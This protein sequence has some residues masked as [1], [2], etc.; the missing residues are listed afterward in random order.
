[1]CIRPLELGADIV[2]H[3]ATKYLA[4]HNDTLAGVLVA[5]AP[6]VA[7]ELNFIRTM[8]GG[9]LAPFDCW[10]TLRGIKTLGVRM[11]RSQEN[12]LKLAMWLAEHPAVRCVYY[13]GL[14]EHAT[15]EIF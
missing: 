11:E 13:P 4:G 12:A 7:D 10:L 1:W 9:V 8:T 2:V 14:K 6:D 5:K 3:S 15:H